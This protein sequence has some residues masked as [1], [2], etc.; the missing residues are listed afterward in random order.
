M[1]V[2]GQ[3]K[4]PQHTHTKKNYKKMKFVF[5]SACFAVMQAMR[6]GM[7]LSPTSHPGSHA[8]CGWSGISKEKCESN[9]ACAY[10]QVGGEEPT[11]FY[12]F[13]CLEAGC[14]NSCKAQGCV[15]NPLVGAQSEVQHAYNCY[16]PNTKPLPPASKS[17]HTGTHAD[18]GYAGIP[19]A[20]CVASGQCAFNGGLVSEPTC[21]WKVD[22]VEYGTEEQCNAK[23]C[24]WDPEGSKG[25]GFFCYLSNSKPLPLGVQP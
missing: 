10:N 17:G 22:C 11:C 14:E 2:V 16:H 7:N 9:H 5:A 13:K 18:C 6:T 3:P 24:T 8:D 12:K 4:V 25:N 20:D 15:W 21:F 1:G 19:E 23:G